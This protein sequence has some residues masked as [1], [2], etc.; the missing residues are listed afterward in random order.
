MATVSVRESGP[1][2]IGLVVFRNCASALWT[3][4]VSG[5]TSFAPTAISKVS[6]S[7]R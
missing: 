3:A 1:M 2:P 7:D 5:G 4:H 6:M